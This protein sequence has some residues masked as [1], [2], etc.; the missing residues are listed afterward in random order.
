MIAAGIFPV[1]RVVTA[2]IDAADVVRDG[3]EALL[4]PS[5]A[6]LKIMVKP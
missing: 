2:T 5:G 1:G 4:D 3:F 6:H